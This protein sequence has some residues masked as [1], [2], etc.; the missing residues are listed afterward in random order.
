[1]DGDKN[2]KHFLPRSEFQDGDGEYFLDSVR[3]FSSFYLVRLAL[4]IADQGDGSASAIAKMLGS[5]DILIPFYVS[6]ES[7]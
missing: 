6:S 4:E 7:A 3:L 5:E 2:G 1:M